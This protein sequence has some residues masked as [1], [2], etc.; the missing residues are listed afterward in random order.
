MVLRMKLVGLYLG[1]FLMTGL[2]FYGWIDTFWGK[3]GLGLSII[4]TIAGIIIAWTESASADSEVII[5]HEELAQGNY[6][7]DPLKLEGDA[8]SL[9]LREAS[10][11][12][13]AKQKQ[14]L[15]EISAASY[16]V[17]S[18]SQQ[19]VH[20]GHQVEANAQDVS[21]AIERIAESAVA[22]AEQITDASQ[23][24]DGLSAEISNVN[25][26]A[27]EMLVISNSVEDNIQVGTKS[28][29]ASIE[30]ME[31][32]RKKVGESAT[33][34]REL[35]EKSAEVG[36]IVTI[37]DGIADQTN[38]LAL[39]ASI[40]AA[41][42]GD[43]GRGFAVVAE[44]V[45]KLAEQSAVST[46]QIRNLIGEIRQDISLAVSSMTEGVSEIA[47][48]SEAI[49]STGQVFDN[50]KA[51]AEKLMNRVSEINQLADRMDGANQRVNANIGEITGVSESFS[52]YSQEVAAAMSEQ[53]NST[54]SIIRG[55][56][57]LAEMSDK[58]STSIAKYNVD[59]TVKWSSAI[60]VGHPMIDSQHQELIARINQLL[61]A[62]SR[63]TGAENV[64]EILDF[65]G[66]YVV[67]HFGDEEREMK[68][69][70]YRGYDGHKEQHTKFINTYL[71]LREE[72]EREGIGPHTAI[73]VNE[74]IVDWLINHITKVDK[75][76]AAF[77]NEAS[78]S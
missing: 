2:G 54:S 27:H 20:A 53:V 8:A 48:G 52:A 43:Q 26:K 6:T 60:E 71:E 51:E 49:A 18:S 7:L 73:Q 33:A 69:Y 12:L 31:D 61:E 32:I 78:R 70:N 14:M 10:N 19:L 45:R 42:A 13:L 72:I 44:E 58:L 4:M 47:D 37:I 46:E 50:I 11:T 15:M 29:Q 68:K 74:I 67:E 36:N 57:L 66:N 5:F 24:V 21:Q 56:E 30:Q 40:E 64:G 65:L 55:S 25:D 9:R 63:G 34:I 76:L 39:N 75:N 16:Q 62:S 3:M 28:I 41:R 23:T 59:V 1:L 38:L 35:E 77:L 17:K 22:L